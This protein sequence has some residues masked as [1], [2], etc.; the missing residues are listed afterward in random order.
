[1]DTIRDP[2]KHLQVR[3]SP[4]H[5]LSICHSKCDKIEGRTRYQIVSI[6]E[7]LPNNLSMDQ[8]L[9]ARATIQETDPP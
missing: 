2:D 8:K 5:S 1:M 4:S 6:L 3:F 7:A 9:L